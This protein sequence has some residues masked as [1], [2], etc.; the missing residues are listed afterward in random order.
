MADNA[1][2]LPQIDLN[3]A[4]LDTLK[5]LPGIGHK[6]AERIIRFR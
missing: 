1:S 2:S 6:L 4:N 3:Q 5:T